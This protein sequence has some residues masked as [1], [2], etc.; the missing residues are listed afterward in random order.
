MYS[1]LGSGLNRLGMG[2]AKVLPSFFRC[3]KN[4]RMYTS[5]RELPKTPTLNW[6]TFLKLRKSRRRFE[7]FTSIPTA[8]LGLGVGSSYFMTRA[9][10]PT[11]TMMGL[12]MFTIY[13]LATIASGALGWLIGPSI[14][15]QVW[16]LINRKQADQIAC[17]EEEFYKHL[18][19][20]RV[21]PSMESYS[22]PI[23]DYY[24]EKIFSLSDYRRW[25]RDQKAYIQR[26]FLRTT[27]RK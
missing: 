14:G 18:K 7:T 27:P 24:G 15:R 26:S 12:D 22:N 11:V 6:P 19:K 20:N 25:L 4:V 13:V 17:R 5:E 23:P 1:V 21:I 10:D 3:V 16:T 2:N 8:A 9:V